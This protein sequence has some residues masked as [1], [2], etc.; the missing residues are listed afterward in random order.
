MSLII[1][2][3][4]IYLKAFVWASVLAIQVDFDLGLQGPYSVWLIVQI[5]DPS[6]CTVSGCALRSVCAEVQKEN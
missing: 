5:Q 3:L 2:S 6:A 1:L 4:R